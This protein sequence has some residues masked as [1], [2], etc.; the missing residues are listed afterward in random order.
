[1]DSSKL[2]KRRFFLALFALLVAFVAAF[3][4]TFAWYIYNTSAH[5]TSVRMAAGA[6]A[7]LEISGEADGTYGSA[8]VLDSFAG[9]LTPVSTDSILGGFQKV[10]GFSNGGE[11]Q[12][13]LVAS[14]FG[15]VSESDYYC[16][17][18]YL[19]TAGSALD[20][21]L[22]EIGYEDSDADAPISTA[23]RVGFVAGDAEAIFAIN[24]AENPGAEYNTATGE[25]GYVLSAS[26]GDGSTV[27]F[28]PY[29]SENFCLYDSATGA[30]TLL[31]GSVALCT[32]EGDG[33][34]G[35]GTPTQVDIYIWLE[36]CD[37]DCT[38]TLAAT[39]LQNLALS[40]VGVAASE[41]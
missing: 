6:S 18:L 22:A 7:S 14:L 28:E 4:A 41:S 10:Y 5:T 16:T 30:A 39:T 13:S 33:S 27:A 31:D 17:T 9:T 34:G 19:R 26:A 2:L 29:T 35:Y 24:G 12:A 15:A 40:F 1:M 11:G 8:A 25:A 23:I 21:Y 20:V 38:N 32:V 3:S 37:P 36:G